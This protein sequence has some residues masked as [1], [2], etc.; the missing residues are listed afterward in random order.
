MRT[1]FNTANSHRWAILW[2]VL[3]TW[4][5]SACGLNSNKDRAVADANAAII[6]VD[7]AGATIAEAIAKLADQDDGTRDLGALRDAG[8]AYL[9]AT[10]HLNGAIRSMSSIHQ[11]L[12]TYIEN[13]F[14]VEAES[15][16][17]D[18]QT[19]LATLNGHDIDDPSLRN[20]ITRL[21]RCIDR[22]ARS[23]D[24]VSKAYS[25]ISDANP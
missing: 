23:V 21:G 15:A 8:A 4:L 1:T 17:S 25:E 7:H 19:A 11:S 22:Y 2:I 3:T 5:L 20:A 16:I 24:G 18:C 14:L 6:E 12:Q 9:T 10:E 13:D